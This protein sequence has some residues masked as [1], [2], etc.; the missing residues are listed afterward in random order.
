MS[1]IQIGYNGKTDW[2]DW[3]DWNGFFLGFFFRNKKNPFQSAESAQS[4]LPLYHHWLI[5]LKK[6]SWHSPPL[7]ISIV[8]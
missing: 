2:A 7:C 6:Q 8:K 4:V 1:C 5:H 3:A